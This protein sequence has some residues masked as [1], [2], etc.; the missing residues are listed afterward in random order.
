[1]LIRLCTIAHVQYQTQYY[2]INR[3]NERFW[4]Y[5][6]KR[7]KTNRK[8]LQS[9]SIAVRFSIQSYSSEYVLFFLL[10]LFIRCIFQLKILAFMEIAS[11][12]QID[13]IR[14]CKLNADSVS[15]GIWIKMTLLFGCRIFLAT[16]FAFTFSVIL[17]IWNREVSESKC[18]TFQS[19][20][21]TLLSVLV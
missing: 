2:N 1:M 7:A 19:L 16:I 12:K 21:A 15:F 11:L 17:A 14:L 9:G 5:S 10:C 13:T 4:N 3:S 18:D 6:I 20:I 8:S